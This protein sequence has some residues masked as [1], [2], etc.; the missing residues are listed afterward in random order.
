FHPRAG[1]SRSRNRDVDGLARLSLRRA[2]HPLAPS[3]QATETD[4][5]PRMR[6]SETAGALRIHRPPKSRYCSRFQR[7]CVLHL[8]AF[9]QLS[10]LCSS[11]TFQSP[12][13]KFFVI[14]ESDSVVL[15]L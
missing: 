11:S 2:K 13:Y 15:A 10:M 8:F 6:L 7:P 5:N 12:L 9:L 14:L 1:R 3:H 4:Q